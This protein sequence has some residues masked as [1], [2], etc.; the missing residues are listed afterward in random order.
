M[1]GYRKVLIALNGSRH[2]L[3]YGMKLAN[4]EKTWITV[5]KVIPPYDGDLHLT[6]IKNIEDALDSN[7]GRAI[8]EIKAAADAEGALL[9]ARLEEGD[10]SSKIVE[11]A[12][13]ERCDLII[14]G[15]P[16]KNWFR[17]LW[18]DNAVEKVINASACPVLVV[19]A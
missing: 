5:V 10:V 16:K 13:D 6:G 19:A 1:K 7:G 18:G 15:A 3:D 12:R 9:K 14:M 2:V 17:K 11:I 4:D 8:A